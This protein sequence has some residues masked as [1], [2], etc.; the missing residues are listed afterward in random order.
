MLLPRE[1]TPQI[2]LD[3]EAEAA[4]KAISVRDRTNARAKHDNAMTASPPTEKELCK[5]CVFLDDGLQMPNEWLATLS[6]YRGIMTREAWRANFF[7]AMNPSQPVNP[8]ITWAAALSGSWVLSPACFLGQ[9][10]PSIKYRPAIFTKRQVWASDS[11]IVNQDSLPYW[12]ALLEI[13]NAFPTTHSWK[14]LVTA[15]QWART[16]AHCEKAKRPAEV[17]ALVSATEASSLNKA[18]AFDMASASSFFASNFDRSR[19]SIGLLGM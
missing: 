14:I 8:L 7:V 11:F 4:R 12:H 1:Q 2:K 17:I 19:G 9:P 3:V 18:G 15:E 5:C 13:L 16:R 6:R 10:G